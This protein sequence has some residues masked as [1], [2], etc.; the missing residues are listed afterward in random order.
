MQWSSEKNKCTAADKK[1]SQVRSATN[2][3]HG[4]HDTKKKKKERKCI[5]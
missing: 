4:L 3:F 2:P 5:Y 1:Q